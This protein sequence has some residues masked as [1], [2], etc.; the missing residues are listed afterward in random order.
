MDFSCENIYD[1]RRRESSRVTA[2]QRATAPKA[3]R[4][5][6]TSKRLHRRRTHRFQ[7]LGPCA[8][9]VC[10]ILAGCRPTPDG[11]RFGTLVYE[12]P[13]IP[14]ADTPYLL[15]DLSPPTEELGSDR[16]PTD[17]AESVPGE[18]APVDGAP[19]GVRRAGE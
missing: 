2:P 1:G 14:G 17:E 4:H 9:L 5:F 6:M 13:A 10:A 12:L 7:R 11:G 16:L 19:V 18:D 15:P 8:A 3:S